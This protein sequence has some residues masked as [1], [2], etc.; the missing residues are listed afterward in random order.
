M[1]HLRIDKAV[2]VVSG[3]G[4]L[5]LLAAYENTRPAMRPAV[6]GQPQ[7]APGKKKTRKPLPP[8]PC[9]L[10]DAAVPRWPAAWDEARPH[11]VTGWHDGIVS[12]GQRSPTSGSQSRPPA[13]DCDRW[14][15]HCFL[16]PA[17]PPGPVAAPWAWVPAADP[18]LST[19]ISRTGPPLS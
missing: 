10:P 13:A 15:W 7:P 19:V 6:E 1:L 8:L 12:C 2:R 4:L 3:V 18:A 9:L 5:V 11:R 17:Q 14:A 16:T